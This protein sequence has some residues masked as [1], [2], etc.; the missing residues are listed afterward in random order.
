V[1]GCGAW[2]EEFQELK[3]TGALHYNIFSRLQVLSMLLINL[4][5]K[6]GHQPTPKHLFQLYGSAQILMKTHTLSKYDH[7]AIRA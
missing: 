7:Y 3:S 6:F 5:T 4:P 2:R 1:N